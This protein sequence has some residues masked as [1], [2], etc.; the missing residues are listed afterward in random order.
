M[1]L[2]VVLLARGMRLLTNR[3]EVTDA[4][5]LLDYVCCCLAER[6]DIGEPTDPQVPAEL[7]AMLEPGVALIAHSIENE[8]AT[9][10]A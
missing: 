7:A 1:D 3:A 2:Y 5:P 4:Q 10:F 8:L 9:A 6:F